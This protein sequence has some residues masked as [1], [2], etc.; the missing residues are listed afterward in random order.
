MDLAPISTILAPR[1]DHDR[2]TI[3]PRSGFDRGPRFPPISIESGESDSAAEIMRSRLD[4]AAILGFFP[5]CSAP[6][7]RG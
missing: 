3:E 1:S 4:H 6:S 2:A 5:V 7:D